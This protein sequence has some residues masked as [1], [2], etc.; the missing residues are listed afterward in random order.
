MMEKKGMFRKGIAVVV[1]AVTVFASTS[2]ILA[3][4]P[5]KSVDE[6][7]MEVV[8]ADEF[9]AFSIEDTAQYDVINEY[10]FSISDEI[11]IFEDGT[12]VPVTKN[13]NSYALCNHIMVSGYYST[14]RS[15]SSG[16]CTVTVYNA[17]QCSRCGYLSLGSVHNVITYAVCTHNN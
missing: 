4:E 9:G 6:G 2:T 16:G 1:T 5:F 12:Q 13:D 8:S 14:H 10:D 17:K 3:Y 7:T 11:F 15:N